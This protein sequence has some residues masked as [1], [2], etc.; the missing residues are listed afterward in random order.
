MH[1]HHAGDGARGSIV[2]GNV[3]RESGNRAFVPHASHGVILRDNIAYDVFDTPYWW[4]P[5]DEHASHDSLWEHNLAAMCASDPVFRGFTMSGFHFGRGDGNVA[6][7]NAAVGVLGNKNCS[8]FH[9]PSQGSGLWEFNANVAHNNKCHG[10][11]VWQNS[12]PN[13]HINDFVA[14]RNRFAGVS[15]GAYKNN[16]VYT[17]LYL[18][19]NGEAG[20]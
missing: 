2:E 10:I 1:F 3:V 14:Y 4:D 18:H 17:D 9:W 20:S 12:S 5:G 16:Y 13:H 11:F 19:S 8:G 7:S 6:N 15:H